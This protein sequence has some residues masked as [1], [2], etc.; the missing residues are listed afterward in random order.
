[1]KMVFDG[2]E[3]DSSTVSCVISRYFTAESAS[4]HAGATSNLS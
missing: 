1:M 2:L 4:I 3:I